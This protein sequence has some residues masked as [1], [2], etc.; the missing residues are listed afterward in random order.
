M[1]I[2]KNLKKFNFK[3]PFS[4]RTFSSKVGSSDHKFGLS[5]K[6][7]PE[8]RQIGENEKYKESFRNREAKINREEFLKRDI[9]TNPEFFKAFP[10]LAEIVKSVNELEVNDLQKHVKEN[11]TITDKGRQEANNNYFETLL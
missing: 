4:M 6:T 1:L 5:E 7:T 9:T 3:F 8:E 11:Y 10:H 2:F